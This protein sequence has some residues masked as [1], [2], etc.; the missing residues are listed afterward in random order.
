MER[1]QE[2]TLLSL[3]AVNAFL[4]RHA[5][6]LARVVATGARQKLRS[7]IADLVTLRSIKSG[8]ALIAQSSTQSK[9]ALRTVLMRD[10]M[11][12]IARIGKSELAHTQE[13]VSLRMP[14]GRRTIPKLVSAADGMAKAAAPYTSV[15]TEN[16]LPADFIVQLNSSA[17]ALRIS[18]TTHKNTQSHRRTVTNGIQ[19]RLSDGRR[20]VRVLD[21]FVRI[22]LKDDPKL[23][24]G[25]NAVQRVHNT[26]T[27][28]TRVVA[29]A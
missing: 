18:D 3:D 10:H 26:R 13:I 7:V 2:N 15:F 5:I 17:E 28:T 19:A 29:A 22:A 12:P 27:A 23:L 11:V 16:G 9:A 20:I 25:W 24:A 8:G 1:A 21:S 14:R 6:Q 4:D